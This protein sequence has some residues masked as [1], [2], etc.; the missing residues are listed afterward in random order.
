MGHKM[1]YLTAEFS[2]CN[3]IFSSLLGPKE[4]QLST[5]STNY[6]YGTKSELRERMGSKSDFQTKKNKQRGWSLFKKHFWYRSKNRPKSWSCWRC[7]FYEKI[8]KSWWFNCLFIKS[9]VK[10]V[11]NTKSLSKV[12]VRENM[13]QMIF[14]CR[15]LLLINSK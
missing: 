8:Q 1:F 11:T 10:R 7:Y 6:R 9:M 13:Y 3:M 14:S 4:V 15:N 2:I 5:T 12:Q